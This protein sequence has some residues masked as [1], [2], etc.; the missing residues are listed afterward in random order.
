MQRVDVLACCRYA[1]PHAVWTCDFSRDEPNVVFAG[2]SNGS[3]S[4]FDLRNTE[5]EVETLVASTARSPV[6]AVRHVGRNNTD[7]M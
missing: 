6:L 1:L 7:A 4:V 3:V 5:K 2:M